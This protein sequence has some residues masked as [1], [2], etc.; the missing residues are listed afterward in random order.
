MSDKAKPGELLPK[1]P[2]RWLRIEYAARKEGIVFNN[3]LCHIN[4]ETVREAYQA[5]D[6]F[7]ALGIDGISK[8]VY[9]ENLEANLENLVARI[10]KGSYKPQAKREVLIPKANG[11]MRPIAISCFEDKLVEW[12]VGK[13][14]QCVYEPIFIETSFGFRE[15]RSAHQAIKAIYYSLADNRRPN[16]VE[17]DFANFFDSISHRKLMKILSKRVSDR[18][19]KGLVGRFLRVGM[20][21][22]SE[23]IHPSEAGTPQGSVMSPVLANLFLHE[24]LDE[25]FLKHHASGSNVIV[26]Y[27]DDVVFLFGSS[28]KAH[29]FWED[30]ENR[31]KQFGLELNKEK[32]NIIC[33]GKYDKTSF[34]FLGFTFYWSKKRRH[35]EASLRV[36][37]QQKTLHKKIQE[38]YLWIKSVRSRLKL[39]EIWQLAILKLIGHY[40]YYGFADNLAKL[41]QFYHEAIRSLF[42][43]LNR[44]SQ[45]SSYNW[46]Q[47]KRRLASN[48]LPTPPPMIKLIHLRRRLIY[49]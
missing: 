44:R 28:S 40:H 48:P 25:W 43:W 20:M 6:G 4:V 15:N 45:K 7:K 13:I 30:L 23:T 8:K 11:K 10:H 3:V 12:V 47:F 42:K 41:N 16:V 1:P 46:E 32:S 34:D 35:V 22:A 26:R 2:N 24:M 36:K 14:L 33:F 9:G 49:A 27:A 19:F 21:G 37:I 38:F 31:I 29:R 5:L 18:R 39:K 17:I